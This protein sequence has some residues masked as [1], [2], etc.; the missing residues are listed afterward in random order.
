MWATQGD[1][2]DR[3]LEHL[4]MGDEHLLAMRSLLDEQIGVVEEG[5]DPINVFRDPEAN[6]CIVPSVCAP[7][8]P[9]ITPD[10]RPDRTNAA[11]K[12][13]EVFT[14]AYRRALGEASL[15]EPVH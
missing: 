12:Y 13:S 4:G 6:E 5:G 9:H 2:M 8:P 11:R 3:T 15:T 7:M 10:G 1:I 14:E